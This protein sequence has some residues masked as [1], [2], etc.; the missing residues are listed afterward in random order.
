MIL[1]GKLERTTSLHA[2]WNACRQ[3]R[4]PLRQLLLFGELEC[5]LLDAGVAPA[6]LPAL[7]LRIAD[8]YLSGA[9]ADFGLPQVPDQALRVR[10]PEGFAFYGV[11]PDAYDRAAVSFLRQHRPQ[12]C[13]V[14]GIRSIGAPLSGVVAATLRRRGVATT[15]QLVRPTGHP[16][17]RVLREPVVPAPVGAHCLIV[18]EGP[19]LSGSSFAA[20]AEAAEQAGYVPDCI[21]LLPSWDASANQL[22][23]ERG[24]AAWRK[25]SRSVA[26]WTL[27]WAPSI[28]PSAHDV[29]AGAWRGAVEGTDD[30]LLFPAHER[31]KFI[32]DGRL[33]KYGGIGHCGD[34]SDRV[35]ERAASHGFSAEFLGRKDGFRHF[36]W[37]GEAAIADPP[38]ETVLQYLLFRATLTREA[39][40]PIDPLREMVSTNCALAGL[41]E[42]A[43][44]ESAWREYA[45]QQPIAVDG[46][47]QRQEWLRAGAR[48]WK[49]DSCDHFC[50]HYLPGAQP[51]AWDVAGAVVELRLS[52]DV[53]GELRRRLAVSDATFACA[54]AAY[55]AF[56]LAWVHYAGQSCPDGP[57]SAALRNA[58]GRYSFEL[59]SH[60]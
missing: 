11:H 31:R 49:A 15:R 55:C 33:A 47:L 50:D 41:P 25:Y 37:Y 1:F 16:H 58:K 60:K 10:T 26:A 42:P 34:A 22:C 7:S 51:V 14:V 38:V 52:P 54:M 23:S 6:E 30:L 44:A 28:P 2:L 43:L 4:E 5:A 27:A 36:R 56:R 21:H 57:D 12:R 32:F 53:A 17:D 46:R 18:D 19:G 39:E 8:S 35:A 40:Q 20:V 29:S 24:Q 59:L 45:A 3:E 9:A 48:W 13:H